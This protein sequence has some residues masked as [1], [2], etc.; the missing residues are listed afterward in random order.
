MIGDEVRLGVPVI[1][2]IARHEVQQRVARR[3][4]QVQV[5]VMIPINRDR[6]GVRAVPE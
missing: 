6:A 3:E 2:E 1:D 4:E 5:A